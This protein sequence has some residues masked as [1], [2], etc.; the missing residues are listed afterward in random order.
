M[1]P[2]ASKPERRCLFLNLIDNA[3]KYAIDAHSGQKRKGAGEYYIFHPLE[4]AAIVSTL[5]SDENIIA[6]AALHDVVEDTEKTVEDIRLNFGDRIAEI[7]S[8]ETENKR[9][10]LPKSET[11]MIRKT[12]TVEDLK[13][14]ADFAEKA[15]ALGDKLSNMRSFYRLKLS[16]GDEMWS[17]FAQ[18]DPAKHWW[19]Y[20]SIAD[21][22]ASEF[23]DTAA[24]KEYDELIHKV[25]D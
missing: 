17:L 13:N 24:W 4:A 1:T 18:K 5:T 25:F 9:P 2:V 14:R 22:L 23:E 6:A 19:Y 3:L 21:A 15:V 11:W 12:E 8:S 16:K 20:R 7:V 10:D